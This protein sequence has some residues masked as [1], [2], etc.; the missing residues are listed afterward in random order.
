MLQ[1]SHTCCAANTKLPPNACSSYFKQYFPFLPGGESVHNYFIKSIASTHYFIK[2]ITSSRNL[3]WRLSF[4]RSCVIN[5]RPLVGCLENSDRK[6]EQFR[7]IPRIASSHLVYSS[8]IQC[9][10]WMCLVLKRDSRFVSRNCHA[11]DI[12]LT[13]SVIKLVH[14]YKGNKA[15]FE[16]AVY[17]CSDRTNVG[18]FIDISL[19]CS[20]DFAKINII[21]TNGKQDV[22][23][24]LEANTDLLSV[25]G[26]ELL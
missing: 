17:Y 2:S 20:V 4:T 1:I 12:A 9:P 25:F 11:T 26:P 18:C 5:T 22:L 24:Q 21:G 14:S 13:S 10:K 3:R 15:R 19:P 16:N 7:V 8:S 6:E 23:K